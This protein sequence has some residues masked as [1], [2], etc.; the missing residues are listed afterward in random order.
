M[1]RR[2]LARLAS[3]PLLSTISCGDDDDDVRSFVS[4]LR[5]PLRVR[6]YMQEAMLFPGLGLAEK[7]KNHPKESIKRS[8][9]VGC[10]C[11]GR[12]FSSFE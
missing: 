7:K 11:W 8:S 2:L 5:L 9:S 6:R 4:K 3:I 1:W 10:W 12:L